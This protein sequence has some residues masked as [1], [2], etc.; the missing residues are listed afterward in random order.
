METIRDYSVKEIQEFSSTLRRKEC[1]RNIICCFI[2]LKCALKIRNLTS[3]PSSVNW[4]VRLDP[5]SALLLRTHSFLSLSHHSVMRDI[6][7]WLS[8]HCLCV[9]PCR[10]SV[11]H[12][13]CLERSSFFHTLLPS[14]MGKK[15]DPKL[16][17][18]WFKLVQEKNALV[19]YES[20]LM[21]LWVIHHRVSLH[22]SHLH[23][24]L[25]NCSRCLKSLGEWFLKNRT[26]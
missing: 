6:P 13:G 18:E 16:M 1:P 9:C 14:G 2:A 8:L 21:I 4:L 24:E 23:V 26:Q 20:E 10:I 22:M 12:T 5:G 17:Q 15:D 25:T 19:R 11:W 7:A 3:T